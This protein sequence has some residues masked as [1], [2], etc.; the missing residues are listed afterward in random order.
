MKQNVNIQDFNTSATVIK[1]VSVRTSAI[2]LLE[3]R[4]ILCSLKDFDLETAY[5]YIR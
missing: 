4:N 3:G 1:N 2:F 5:T